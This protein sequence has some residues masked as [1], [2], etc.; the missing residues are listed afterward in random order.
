VNTD[1]TIDRNVST[2]YKHCL[3][4]NAW[5]ALFQIYASFLIH[6]KMDLGLTHF[7]G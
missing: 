1:T 3:A 2:Q 4:M 6:L 5:G 7:A